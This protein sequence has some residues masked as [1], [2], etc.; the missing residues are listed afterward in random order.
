MAAVLAAA[1]AGAAPAL[2]L[3]RG[4]PADAAQDRVDARVG[5]GDGRGQ[6]PGADPSQDQAPTGEGRGRIRRGEWGPGPYGGVGG[7]FGPVWGG[8]FDQRPVT[9]GE[10]DEVVA[11]MTRYS[12]WRIAEVEKIPEGDLKERI[13]RG[14]ANRYRGLR[15]LENRDPDGYEQ[16][17]A[18]LAVED[19]VFKLVSQWGGADEARRDAIREELRTQVARLVD[20]DLQERG[21]RVQR[22]EDELK[23]Q[24]EALDKD[25]SGRDGLVEKRVKGF[26]DW[27]NK[28]PGRVKG[29]QKPDGR[30]GDKSD[31]KS[32]G[33]PDAAR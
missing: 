21:R 8:R 1:V 17:L 13:K 30:P 20:L 18:Q 22:L 11:F 9:P 23:K 16:R 6:G 5:R 33:K 31:A 7:P 2:W 26:L 14:L 19:Q 29:K 24:K 10:W 15:A 25:T 28:W 4:E 3:A 32:D 12:P 27:G